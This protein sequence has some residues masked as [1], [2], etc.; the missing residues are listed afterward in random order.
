MDPE[1]LKEE[2]AK[3][4]KDDWIEAWLAFEAVAINKEIAE[5]SLKSHV[6]RMGK[7]REIFIYEKTTKES[8]Q[9]KEVPAH[10]KKKLP[11]DAQLWSH[12]AEVRALCK[13]FYSLLNLVV[14]FGPSAVEIIGPN[15][16]IMKLDEMQNIANTIAGLLHEFAAAGVGGVI[17]SGERS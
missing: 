8:K 6:E 10:L 12:V 9:M 15:S 17:I 14:L 5:E 3:K 7:S 13:D 2:V 1:K 16:K 11:A 4:R